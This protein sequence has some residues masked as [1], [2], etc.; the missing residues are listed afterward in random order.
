MESILELTPESEFKIFLPASSVT[1]I[2]PV[3]TDAT[4][5]DGPL[6]DP[7]WIPRPSRDAPSDEKRVPTNEPSNMDP[8][9]E[10]SIAEPNNVKPLPAS[11]EGP[12]SAAGPLSPRSPF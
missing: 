8:K 12:L 4:L 9:M 3:G 5:C 6:S 1:K 11:P 7:T 2:C 10:P